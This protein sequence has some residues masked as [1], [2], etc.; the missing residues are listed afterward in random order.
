MSNQPKLQVALDM[1]DLEEALSKAQAIADYVDIIEIGTILAFSEGIAAVK[2]ISAQFT[3]KIIVCDMKITD[4]SAILT[5][6][7]FEAGAN[8]VTVSAAAHIETIRTAK[9]IADKYQ[10]QI[11]IELYGHWTEDDVK[12]WVHAGIEHAILHLPRDAELAGVSWNE[13][14]LSVIDMLVKHGLKVSVTGGIKYDTID[15]FNGLKVEA[16]IVGRAFTEDNGLQ[17]AQAFLNKIKHAWT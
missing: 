7:A 15:K 2:A 8:W 16:F 9:S 3:D 13:S 4:A 5:K 1:H 6:M 17:N 10:G 11:Q 12:A 14:H